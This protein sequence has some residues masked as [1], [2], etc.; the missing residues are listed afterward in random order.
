MTGDATTAA[1]IDDV[2]GQSMRKIRYAVAVAMTAALFGCASGEDAATEPTASTT[3]DPATEGPMDEAEDPDDVAESTDEGR[4]DAE[5]T[6][7]DDA[8]AEGSSDE[9]SPDEGASDLGSGDVQATLESVTEVTWDEDDDAFNYEVS[10]GGE[11]LDTTFGP[12]FLLLA[13]YGSGED[14]TVEAMEIGD[15]SLGEMDISIA[16]TERMVLR[17]DESQV[18]NAYVGMSVAGYGN[19]TSAIHSPYAIEHE[20]DTIDTLL[21]GEMVSVEEETEEG[22]ST[23]FRAPFEFSGSDVV[24]LG[25]YVELTVP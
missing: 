24:E 2:K 1:H 4:S 25:P 6:G 23:T 22:T 3:E 12:P 8:S 18:P 11:V 14:V 16:S 7:T 5:A 9:V 13:E 19:L 15:G 21:F 17:W 20:P 10:V